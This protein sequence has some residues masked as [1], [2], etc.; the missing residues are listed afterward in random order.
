MSR[1]PSAGAPC[2][3]ESV[4]SSPKFAFSIRQ[5][6][7]SGRIAIA[8]STELEEPVTYSSLAACNRE[9][10]D[11]PPNRVLGRVLA[12]YEERDEIGVSCAPLLACS[13]A[14]LE[15]RELRVET[16]VRIPTSFASLPGSGQKS[17]ASA[18]PSAE[19]VVGN[20]T[21]H[22]GAGPP[23][24]WHSVVCEVMRGG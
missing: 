11:D 22:A 2:G 19:S 13:R 7:S 5:R 6:S 18:P 3:D 17:G 14:L 9:V 1:I 15:S 12:T 16:G 4:T 23:V 10:F 20:V 21:S 24:Q 8:V